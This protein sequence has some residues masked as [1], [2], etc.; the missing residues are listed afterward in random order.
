[1]QRRYRCRARHAL[2]SLFVRAEDAAA[3]SWTPFCKAS[4]LPACA[5]VQATQPSK[6]CKQG[7]E[8]HDGAHDRDE[9]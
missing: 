4:A 8:K 6:P 9:Q 7:R 2:I 1:M 3:S 5:A